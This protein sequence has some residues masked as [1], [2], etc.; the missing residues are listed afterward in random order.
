MPLTVAQ[1]ATVRADII[2]NSDLNTNPHTTDGNIAVALLYNLAASP[3]FLV[4]RTEAPVNDVL[5]SINW[6][7]YTPNTGQ[8]DNTVTWSN[9]ILYIQ[10][11][12]INLQNMTLGRLSINASKAKIRSALLDATTSVPSGAAGALNDPGGVN[13]VNT[14]TA[15]T[16]KATRIEKLLAGA[17]ATTGAVTA[18]LLI[19]EGAVTGSDIDQA[20]AN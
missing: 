15:C 18:T 5:D 11:K 7:Q 12:Q 3:D 6:A 4:W 17:S 19:F 8:L 9:R 20:R 16:R 10:S 1:L 13:G 2:A 14:L